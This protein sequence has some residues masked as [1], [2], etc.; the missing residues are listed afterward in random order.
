[1]PLTKLTKNKIGFFLLA[2]LVG[3]NPI[4][5]VPPGQHLTMTCSTNVDDGFKLAF[6]AICATTCR[7]ADA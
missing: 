3:P 1:M 6:H 5:P 4:S 7:S 2:G